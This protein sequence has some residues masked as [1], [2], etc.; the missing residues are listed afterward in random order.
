MGL[1]LQAPPFCVKSAGAAEAG[2][3]AVEAF[4]TGPKNVLMYLQIAKPSLV[5]FDKDGTLIDFD[6]MWNTWATTFS[7]KYDSKTQK[8]TKKEKK[9]KYRVA[10]MCLALEC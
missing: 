9:R 4:D 1:R 3:G 7:T 10:H 6:Q 2:G 8:K 5:I